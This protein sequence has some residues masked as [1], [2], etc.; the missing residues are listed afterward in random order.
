[1]TWWDREGANIIAILAAVLV[2]A[3]IWVLSQWIS[4][5]AWA[6]VVGAA[7]GFLAAVWLLTNTCGLASAKTIVA[8]HLSNGAQVNR[9]NSSQRAGAQKRQCA[10]ACAASPGTVPV[11]KHL[12]PPSLTHTNISP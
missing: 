9:L 3:V 5:D 1:M 10:C 6:D 8:D 7:G 2:G 4:E 11:D 12:G